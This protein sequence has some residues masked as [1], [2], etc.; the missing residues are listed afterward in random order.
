[1]AKQFWKCKV[2]GDIH[3]GAAGPEVCPTCKAQNA[4]EPAEKEAAKK[5]MAL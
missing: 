1:M 5:A 3:Y 2:C 4:Y